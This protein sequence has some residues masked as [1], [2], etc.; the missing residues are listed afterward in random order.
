M[1]E[2]AASAASSSVQEYLTFTLGREEYAI[3]IL[4]VQEIRGYHQV[5]AIANAPA[6]IKGVINLRG[7]I[8]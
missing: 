7:A 1:S 8:V 2:A 5:T 3:D 6:F 4:R